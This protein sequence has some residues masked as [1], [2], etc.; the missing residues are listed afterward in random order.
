ML[1][2]RFFWILLIV[3]VLAAGGGYYYYHNVYAEP[4]EAEE[5]TIKTT[6]VRRGDLTISASGSGELIPADDV[7][8]GFTT[9]GVLAEVLVEVGDQVQASDVLARLDVE[10][11]RRALANAELKVAQAEATLASQQDP[12]AA[13]RTVDLAEL[14]VAQSELNLASAQLKLDELLDWAPDEGGVAIAQANLEA[15]QASYEAAAS[16]SA[17]DQTTSA[18]I[19]LQQAQ[20]DLTDAQV[21][22]NEVWDPA[23]DWELYDKRLGPRLESERESAVRSVE[24]A[25]QNL[26][27]AQANYNLALGNINN[28]GK[29]NAWTQVLNAQSALEDAQLG[30]TDTDIE[31]ARLAVQQAELSL[32]QARINLEEA[33]LG[34]DTTQAELSLDQARLDLEAA[35][36]AL[37]RLELQA[38][39]TGLVTTL[40]AQVGQS[41]GTSPI[42]TLSNLDQAQVVLYLD[43]TDLGNIATGNEVEVIFDA[44]PDDTFTGRVTRVEPE[45][46]TVEGVPTVQAVAALEGTRLQNLPAGLNASV[47]VIGGRAEN[48]LLLSVEAL[49]ELAPGQYAVFVVDPNGELELRPVGVGLMDFANAEILSGLQQGDEVSTGIVDTN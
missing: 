9:S 44:L 30:P 36:S 1:R 27:V 41:V 23:R 29:L 20:S 28:A 11:A 35:Q 32:A 19:S 12:A 18:R 31:E 22:Y 40:D 2:N 26:E 37:N 24:R 5:E 25:Q 15:A 3:I 33:Q 43:E 16:E 10:D 49:R 42:V 47:E 6:R 48:A 4:V 8:L 46:V 39:I 45:L 7:S 34:V 17:Y 13:K 14:Q 38:P 21:T